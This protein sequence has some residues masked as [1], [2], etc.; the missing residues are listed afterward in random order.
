[1][2][3]DLNPRRTQLDREASGYKCRW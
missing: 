1:M 3:C 2:N